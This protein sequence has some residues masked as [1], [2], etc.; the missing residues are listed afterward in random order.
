MHNP[1][2]AGRKVGS[3]NKDGDVTIYTTRKMCHEMEKGIERSRQALDKQVRVSGFEH[4]IGME[5]PTDQVG[6]DYNQ[7]QGDIT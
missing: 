1:K 5:Q 4:L 7:A 6:F 3:T 2:G